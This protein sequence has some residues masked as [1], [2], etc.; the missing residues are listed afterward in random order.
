MVIVSQFLQVMS[1]DKF[2]F[3]ITWYLS[4]ELR[5]LILSLY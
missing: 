3:G 5:V 2:L 1:K 4:V